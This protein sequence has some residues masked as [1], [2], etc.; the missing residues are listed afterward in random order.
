MSTPLFPSHLVSR[1][2][3]PQVGGKNPTVRDTVES[4]SAKNNAWRPLAKLTVKRSSVGVAFLNGYL[5]AVG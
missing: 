4:Y 3:S 1:D 2:V 5:Y